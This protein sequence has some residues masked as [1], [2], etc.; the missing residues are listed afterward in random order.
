MKKRGFLA[1]ALLGISLSFVGCKD[2]NE[3]VINFN[4]YSQFKDIETAEYVNIGEYKNL[5]ITKDVI[6]VSEIEVDKKVASILYDAGYYVDANDQPVAAGNKIKISMTGEV[7]GSSNAGFTQNGFEFVYGYDQYIMDGFIENLAG[8]YQGE[9]LK[10]DVVIPATF[11]EKALVGKTASFTVSIDNVQTYFVPTFNDEFVQEISDYDTMEEYRESL[12]PVIKEDKLSSIKENKR[13]GVWQLVSD[14]S[15]VISYPE[16]SLEKKE[17]QLKER[18][19]MSALMNNMEVDEYT[20]NYFGMMYEEY[21][22]YAIKQDLLL[23]AI[24]RAE[25]I[26]LTQKEY[27]EGLAKYASTYGYND[28]KTFIAQIGEDKIKET[29]LWDKV[30]NFIADQA[31]IEE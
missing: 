7:D 15:S 9:V 4:N 13:L 6:G 27:E 28:T 19:E 8:A 21:I 30:M 31:K 11:S 25:N 14:N 10:F 3:E 24:G 17:A 16:G 12:I 18:I 22:Q 5:V 2:K 26:T 20:V 1:I 23:D 29:L